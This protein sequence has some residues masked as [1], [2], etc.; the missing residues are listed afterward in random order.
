MTTYA[1]N[2]YPFSLKFSDIIHTY[3]KFQNKIW[4]LVSLNRHKNIILRCMHI[5]VTQHVVMKTPT[6]TKFNFFP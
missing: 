3:E 1:L 5:N 2:K 4:L 6:C